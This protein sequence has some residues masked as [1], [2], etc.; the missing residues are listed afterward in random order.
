MNLLQ[1]E[2]LETDCV[3]ETAAIAVAIDA[4]KQNSQIVQA[5]DYWEISTPTKDS[6]GKLLSFFADDYVSKL[7]EYK[8]CSRTV[9]SYVCKATGE[10]KAAGELKHLADKSGYAP[11]HDRLTIQPDNSTVVKYSEGRLYIKKHKLA[12]YSDSRVSS[13]VDTLVALVECGVMKHNSRTGTTARR[14]R[15]AMQHVLCR[16]ESRFTHHK[17]EWQATFNAELSAIVA[18]ALQREAVYTDDGMCYLWPEKFVAGTTKGRRIECSIKIYNITAVQDDRKG[19]PYQYL[20]GDV[21]KFEITFNHQFFLRQA[22]SKPDFARIS[23]FKS[24][25]DIFALLQKHIVK[26]FK[27]FVLKP[28]NNDELTAFYHATGTTSEVEFMRKL[29]NPASLQTNADNEMATITT[30]QDAFEK[31]IQT[32][33]KHVE[34]YRDDEIAF[35]A[36]TTA[37]FEKINATL[38]QYA[39]SQDMRKIRPD[40][41]YKPNTSY[42]H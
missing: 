27:Q 10:L 25:H 8:G 31:T 11:M 19:K 41:A 3:I 14:V 35:R 23:D 37:E 21:F 22:K 6:K 36:K 28:L 39:A 4:F 33:V 24:Q 9:V 2:C 29:K 30:R 34:Y 7:L 13:M 38:A 5:D 17:F 42:C 26:Q 16:K 12:G 32:L 18:P 40:A 15:D 20:P 1:L